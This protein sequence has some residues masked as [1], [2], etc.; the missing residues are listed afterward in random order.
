LPLEAL[1]RD[2]REERDWREGAKGQQ[3]A[4]EKRGPRGAKNAA[5]E[6]RKASALPQART[7]P[8]KARS[9]KV[10]PFGAPLPLVREGGMNANLGRKKMRREKDGG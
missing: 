8:C 10:A 2:H 4:H 9:Y 6:R 3:A 7:A 5:V 1:E